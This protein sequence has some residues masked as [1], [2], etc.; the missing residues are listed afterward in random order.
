MNEEE[1]EEQKKDIQGN[2]IGELQ[3]DERKMFIF[4]NTFEFL[5]TKLI[6]EMTTFE[7][8]P[9]LQVLESTVQHLGRRIFDL[10]N[11]SIDDYIMTTILRNQLSAILDFKTTSKIFGHIFGENVNNKHSIFDD[12][13]NP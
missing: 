7:V 9:I 2:L 13:F 10:D 5:H 4:A 11:A 12:Y 8:Y 1:K 3:K 6:T